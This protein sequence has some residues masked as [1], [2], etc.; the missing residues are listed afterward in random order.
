MRSNAQ[1]CAA[2]WQRQELALVRGEHLQLV[3]ADAVLADAMRIAQASCTCLFEAQLQR[4][5]F[6]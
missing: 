2:L 6:G 5:N 4:F 3:E 1:R